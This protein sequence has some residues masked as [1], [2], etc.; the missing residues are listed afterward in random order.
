MKT[1]NEHTSPLVSIIIVTYNHEDF[2]VP[3][4]DYL[5]YQTYT[6]FETIVVDNASTDGTIERIE[7]SDHSP[8]LIRNASN[9][10]FAG[11]NNDGWRKSGGELI[12]LLNPDVQVEPDWL[13]HL[14][15]PFSKDQSIG[16]TGCKLY[17]PNSCTIQ[18]AGGVLSPNALSN[19]IGKGEEDVGQYDMEK[20]VEY[21]TGAS[22]AV[23]RNLLETLGGLDEDYNPGYYE[24]SDLC[25]RVMRLRKRVLYVPEARAYHYESPNITPESPQF[26]RLYFRNRMRFVMKRYT[27]WKFITVFLPGEIAWL[28]SSD[29]RLYRRYQFPAYTSAV[30]FLFSRRGLSGKG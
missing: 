30:P 19:H 12:V 28:F 4:L 10:G 6:N 20:D 2:I 8:R 25:A 22:L 7:K 24:E 3:C 5:S 13:E 27:V 14:I 17:Y 9:R 1:Q 29:S 26:L 21:V 15:A 16:I 11:G 18:H 23:Q